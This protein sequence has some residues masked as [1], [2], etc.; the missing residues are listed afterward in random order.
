[1]TVANVSA[2]HVARQTPVQVKLLGGFELSVDGSA[3]ETPITAQRLIAF[4][5]LHP[6]ALARGYVAGALWL[7]KT[8]ARAAS[9]LRSSLWR[10]RPLGD[11]LIQATRTHLRLCDEI[12]VDVAEADA[13]ARRLLPGTLR[14]CVRPPCCAEVS[15]CRTGTTTG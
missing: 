15:C 11:R 3:I 9:N 6:R 12:H 8:D 13:V 1:M 2:P 14:I 4:L 7:D 5:A 10:T